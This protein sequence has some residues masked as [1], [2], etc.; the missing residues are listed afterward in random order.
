[1]RVG[2]CRTDRNLRASIGLRIRIINGKDNGARPILASLRLPSFL[3][4]FSKSIA[5][6]HPIWITYAVNKGLLL[7]WIQIS[8]LADRRTSRI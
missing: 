7:P 5:G 4:R 2:D 1:M 8:F 6:D 3:G